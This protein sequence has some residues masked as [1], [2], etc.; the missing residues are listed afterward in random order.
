MTNIVAGSGSGAIHDK[1]TVVMGGSVVEYTIGGRRYPYKSVAR[2]SVCQSQ[3]RMQIEDGILTG[4]TYQAILRSLPEDMA[5]FTDRSDA[6]SKA[7]MQTHAKG[8]M[9]LDAIIARQTIEMRAS[10]RGRSLDDPSGSMIDNHTLAHEIV[11][12]VGERLARGELKPNLDHAL[13]AQ[14]LLFDEEARISASV[15]KDASE[16]AVAALFGTLS[17]N[18]AWVQYMLRQNVV[19]PIDVLEVPRVEDPSGLPSA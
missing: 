16:E 2:C 6:I 10:D 12:Q 11:R 3:Y 7:N 19:G 4:R 5:P 8:H 18:P 13:V 14:K 9:P 17:H 15:D 1:G